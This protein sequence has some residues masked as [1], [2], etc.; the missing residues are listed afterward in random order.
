MPISIKLP[1]PFC[2]FFLFC[3]VVGFDSYSIAFAEV[4]MGVKSQVEYNDNILLEEAGKISDMMY[5]VSPRIDIKGQRP[6]LQATFSYHP[7]YTWYEKNPEYDSAG[8]L[9]GLDVA[10]DVS[11][12]VDISFDNRFERTEEGTSERQDLQGSTRLPYTN[13]SSTLSGA[14]AMGTALPLLI[15]QDS[16]R[17]H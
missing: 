16:K 5:R 9:V 3:L 10:G 11:R 2:L 1:L 8:H 14:W 17:I 13:L 15:L 12:N 4:R 6:R 7:S